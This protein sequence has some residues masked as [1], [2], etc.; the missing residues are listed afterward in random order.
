[1][2]AKQDRQTR[3]IELVE[4][5]NLSLSLRRIKNAPGWEGRRTKRALLHAMDMSGC[6]TDGELENVRTAFNIP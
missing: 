2:N 6:F 3:L 5:G 1:M 4:T